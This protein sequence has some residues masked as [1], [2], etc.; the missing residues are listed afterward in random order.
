[1]IIEYIPVGL[2]E[3]NPTI[4]DSWYEITVRENK[5][6][7]AITVLTD[8]A[9][10]NF[11]SGREGAV[12]SRKESKHGLRIYTCITQT[13]ALP[14][15][16]SHLALLHALLFLKK[17][18]LASE[19]PLSRTTSTKHRELIK[20]SSLLAGTATPPSA[21]TQPIQ[22]KVASDLDSTLKSG[23]GL[24]PCLLQAAQPISNPVP[25][26]ALL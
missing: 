5:T 16:L 23:L 24:Q 9:C 25:I 4:V 19:L 7:K 20:Q 2:K 17:G 6:S 10:R 1:M 22:L 12:E 13:L 11:T 8:M 26:N 21:I 18:T 15:I 14:K 3:E